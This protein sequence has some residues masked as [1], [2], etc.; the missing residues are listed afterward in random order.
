MEASGTSGMKAAANGALNISIPDGWWC[1]A[2]LLGENGWSIGKGETYE[3]TEEQDLIESQALYEILEQEVAPMFYN[4]DRVRLPREWMM[5]MKTSIQ[6]IVPM[7]N[8]YRMVLEYADRFYVPCCQRRHRLFQNNRKPVYE[9]AEKK[10]FITRHWPSV[11][12]LQIESGPT[13]S[14]YFG[15]AL[16]ITARI[17]LGDLSPSDVNV[18]TYYGRLDYHGNFIEG[19]AGA[20]TYDSDLG[21]GEYRYKGIAPCDKTG[22][23][24]CTVRVIPSHPDFLHKH[25]MGLIQWA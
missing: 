6:T 9:L 2:E 10:L 23:T 25:E 19:T 8:T 3:D 17:H 12:I 16:E 5:R 4:Y 7:F 14:L 1:E 13:E 15:D 22:S 24:G 18:E 21:N 11:K 20:M